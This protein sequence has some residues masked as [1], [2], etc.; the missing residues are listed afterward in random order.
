VPKILEKDNAKNRKAKK[1]KQRLRTQ[2]RHHLAGGHEDRGKE[3][4][5]IRNKEKTTYP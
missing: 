2:E 1:A 5:K 4:K 3:I